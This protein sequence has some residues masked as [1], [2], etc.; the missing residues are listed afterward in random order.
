MADVFPGAQPQPAG[1]AR[2]TPDEVLVAFAGPAPQR[3]G[4]VLVRVFMAIPHLIVLYALNIAAEV[5]A[6][7]CW[8]ALLFTGRRPESL[9]DF[10]AGWLRWSARVYGYLWLLTDRY[11]PFELADPDYPVR[12]SVAP[13]PL[14]RLAVFFRFILAIPAALLLGLLFWGTSTLVAFVAWIIVLVRGSLPEPLH[15]AFAAVLRY[16]VRYYG[17]FYLLSGTYPAGLFGDPPGQDAAAAAEA[18][19][20]APTA[21]DTPAEGGDETRA[22]GA[23]SAGDETGADGGTAGGGV[24]PAGG[25]EAG[26]GAPPAAAPGAPGGQPAEQAP[27]YGQAPAY[28]AAAGGLLAPEPHSWRLV[29]SDPAKRLVGLFIALGVILLA[30]CVVLIVVL[31]VN[32]GNQANARVTIQD[33]H[34][35][36]AR[37]LSAYQAGVQACGESVSC[38]TGQDKKAAQ[39]FGSFG[40]SVD[41]TSV[42]SGEATSARARLLSDTGK[43][44]SDLNQLSTAKSAVQYQQ[45]VGSTGLQGTVRDFQADY[46]RLGVALRHS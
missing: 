17:Y 29:L 40:Q 21:G 9:A 25:T 45:I 13:G 14:N 28:P 30:G 18:G 34:S 43:I 32:A 12:V 42:P 23:P 7:I 8:F 26:P 11:P 15:E 41:G 27:G 44:K 24:P 36:L 22:D 10:L 46:T 33:A 37:S 31:S 1:L 35:R 3:R 16:A 19:T 5:V 39:A 20:T 6:V 4:T 38:V 2:Q